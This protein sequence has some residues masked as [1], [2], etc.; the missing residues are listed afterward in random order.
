MTELGTSAMITIVIKSEKTALIYRL[1]GFLEWLKVF[2][3]F[4]FWFELVSG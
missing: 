4:Q 1:F 3:C 2:H